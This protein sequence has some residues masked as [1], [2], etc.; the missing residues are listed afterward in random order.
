MHGH[1]PLLRVIYTF[2]P[3]C[4]YEQQPTNPAQYAFELLTTETHDRLIYLYL[5]DLCP[6]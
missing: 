5:L 2:C 1:E 3:R 6:L 4:V